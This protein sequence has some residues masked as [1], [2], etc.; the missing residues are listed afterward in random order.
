MSKLVKS[1]RAFIETRQLLSPGEAVV[2]GVSG[3]MDSVVLM[4][5]LIAL[6]ISPIIA[7]VNYKLRGEASDLDE[8]FVRNSAD[9][10]GLACYVAS[11]DTATKAH[12]SRRSIQDLARSLRYQHF[13]RVAKACDVS[14]IAVGHHLDDQAETVLLNIFRGCGIEGL[15]GMSDMRPLEPGSAVRV[16]RPFLRVGRADI[17]AF[18]RGQ[19][20][21]WR[22]D[23]S[24]AGSKYRRNVIRNEIMPLIA[25]H[26]GPSSSGRI[27]H[28]AGLVRGYISGGLVAKIEEAF[29]L[30]SREEGTG[31]RLSLDGL[32]G[33]D[34]T[35]R[36]RLI[37][38]GVK[39][40]I[41]GF[42]YRETVAESIDRLR[43]AQPGRRVL[44]PHG[45]VWRTR[46]SILFIPKNYS[47]GDRTSD[48]PEPAV[49]PEIP[50]HWAAGTLTVHPLA[51]APEEDLTA[52]PSHLEFID[53][54]TLR[55]PLTLR[56]W[57]PG[58]RFQPLGM[59][60]S[61]K[62]SDFLTDRKVPV[63]KRGEVCVLCSEESI[64]WVVGHRVSQS[65]RVGPESRQFARLSFEPG[66][67]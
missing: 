28:T 5:V 49:F 12:E 41:P 63:E 64:I 59:S 51:G 46:K 3:G 61:K 62:V 7:H 43:G 30:I 60:H 45:E 14:R 53:A 55:F 8:A 39:R 16:V 56:P 65:V 15:A 13:S 47:T 48:P 21:R 38:E 50:V 26:F 18:A 10:L 17:E 58:D 2:V 24:N 9:E 37:L 27:A 35:W 19:S 54:E 57:R 32:A 11:H 1:T 42:P 22:E 23:A 66:R 6:G 36:R 67:D 33:F 31:G 44:C 29:A 25:H 34:M 4:H 20:L 52:T 40:W